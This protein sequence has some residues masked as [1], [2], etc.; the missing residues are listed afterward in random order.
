MGAELDRDA[1]ALDDPYMQSIEEMFPDEE[2]PSEEED[3]SKIPSQESSHQAEK[4]V[5]TPMQRAMIWLNRPLQSLSP[6]WRD[7]VGC[8]GIGTALL[9]LVLICFAQGGPV[10]GVAAAVVGGVVGYLA[11]RKLFLC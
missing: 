6:M 1:T 8:S 5:L 7:V 11:F 4:V 9:G 2:E 10:A 3:G